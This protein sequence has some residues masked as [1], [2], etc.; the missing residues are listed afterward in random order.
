MC[1]QSKNGIFQRNPKA[2]YL[3]IIWSP[4]TV[5]S[6]FTIACMHNHETKIKIIKIIRKT[7]SSPWFIA[8]CLN[9]TYSTFQ[10]NKSNLLNKWGARLLSLL[11]CPLTSLPCTY[12]RLDSESFTL[13]KLADNSHSLAA[14]TTGLINQTFCSYHTIWKLPYT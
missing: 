4:C 9:N 6:K 12:T 1:W 7:A 14:T 8:R 2:D 5:G 11:G 13:H 3:S 10:G